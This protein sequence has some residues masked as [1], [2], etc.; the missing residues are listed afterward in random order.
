MKNSYI[1]NRLVDDKIKTKIFCMH[2]LEQSDYKDVSSGKRM[3]SRTITC[4]KCKMSSKAKPPDIIKKMKQYRVVRTKL[5]LYFIKDGHSKIYRK[6]LNTDEIKIVKNRSFSYYSNYIMIPPK[7]LY[8]HD[9][10]KRYESENDSEKNMKEYFWKILH[11]SNRYKNLSINYRRDERILNVFDTT[12][13]SKIRV[14]NV[15]RLDT[16][17]TLQLKLRY[18]YGVNLFITENNFWFRKLF[19]SRT[20][21]FNKEIKN[22]SHKSIKLYN[23]YGGRAH[24][25]IN[26]NLLLSNEKD[27]WGN[28]SYDLPK[29]FYSVLDDY[30]IECKSLVENKINIELNKHDFYRYE[31]ENILKNSLQLDDLLTLTIYPNVYHLW[32]L[33]DYKVPPYKLFKAIGKKSKKQYQLLKEED[34]QVNF[35]SDYFKVKLNKKEKSFIRNYPSL[36]FIV[37]NYF[38]SIE[39]KVARA[40]ILKRF[41]DIFHLDKHLNKTLDDRSFYLENVNKITK[42]K[43]KLKMELKNF[44]ESMALVDDMVY[45]SI[46]FALNTISTDHSIMYYIDS[47]LR[48]SNRLIK[49]ISSLLK[50]CNFNENITDEH[51]LLVKAYQKDKHYGLTTLENN[52][53]KLV[54]DKPSSEY[55]YGDQIYRFSEEQKSKY[56]KTIGE[57]SFELIG[58]K[59]RLEQIGRIMNNCVGYGSYWEAI[60]ANHL[61]I[62]YGTNQTKNVCMEINFNSDIVQISTKSNRSISTLDDESLKDINEYIKLVESYKSI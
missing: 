3:I 1:V 19:A 62:V 59:K 12:I 11:P 57:W 18:L 9:L 26:E 38:T 37:L 51:V 50:Y 20:Y 23:N 21:S 32:V 43:K 4:P 47:V 36:I 7:E 35:I 10:N 48:K 40:N 16:G 31:K 54:N 28:F 58:F 2:C 49:D 33:T 13:F 34:N 6:D 15:E 42:S 14:L 52:L 24:K 53:I 46:S 27:Y 8:F 5:Y 60:T 17:K 25:F 29:E 30:K 45:K 41:E 61:L 55:L 44:P 22:L 56:N 39:N